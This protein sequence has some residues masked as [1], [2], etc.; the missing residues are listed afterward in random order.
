MSSPL[1]LLALSFITPLLVS[2]DTTLLPTVRCSSN[3][4]RLDLA[5]KKF[6]S[7]CSDQTFF[8]T[9]TCVPR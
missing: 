9:A 7:D 6:I 2:A 8:A 4:N 3:N 1:L 5:S